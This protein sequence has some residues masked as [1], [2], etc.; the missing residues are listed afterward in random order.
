MPDL[1][2]GGR[3]QRGAVYEVDP[4]QHVVARIAR[5]VERRAGVVHLEAVRARL[6]LARRAHREPLQV[7][8]AVRFVALREEQCTIGTLY[9][10]FSMCVLK[11][12]TGVNDYLGV[13]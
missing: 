11:F 12:L 2:G 1:C 10:Q 9:S 4:G 7:D 3:V 8:H 5:E 13:A 6:H